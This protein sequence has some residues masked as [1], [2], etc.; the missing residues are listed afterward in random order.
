MKPVLADLMVPAAAILA[1][2]IYNGYLHDP[3]MARQHTTLA[4]EDLDW[5]FRKRTQD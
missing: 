5:T 1:A 2:S 3:K 4:M